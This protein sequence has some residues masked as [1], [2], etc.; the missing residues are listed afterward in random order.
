MSLVVKTV[1]P[2]LEMFISNATNKEYFQ[3]LL[4]TFL[5]EVLSMDKAFIDD[6]DVCDSRLLYVVCVYIARKAGLE[7]PSLDVGSIA[8]DDASSFPIGKTDQRLK[9]ITT[10][11]V[12]YRYALDDIKPTLD[13]D[14]YALLADFI[15]DCDF[16]LHPVPRKSYFDWIIED[17][18]FDEIDAYVSGYNHDDA[19]IKQFTRNDEAFSMKL[20]KRRAASNGEAYAAAARLKIHK[21]KW[22]HLDYDLDLGLHPLIDFDGKHGP[23]GVVWKHIAWHVFFDKMEKSTSSIP[24]LHSA[25]EKLIQ[26]VIETRGDVYQQALMTSGTSIDDRIKSIG[27]LR[28][29]LN[30]L[31]YIYNRFFFEWSS[32]KTYPDVL[33]HIFSLSEPKKHIHAFANLCQLA[34]NIFI[35]KIRENEARPH[36]SIPHSHA[37]DVDILTPSNTGVNMNFRPETIVI[38][39]NVYKRIEKL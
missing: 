22:S 31:R 37:G 32:R 14:V 17:E 16:E 28:G 20:W 23:A 15:D 34:V 35:L 4:A 11:C 3:T 27:C 38:N 33:A 18:L 30:E 5:K 2:A 8:F 24:E 29:H 26:N 21:L 12:K 39:G 36:N 25:F 7:E 6:Y 13:G 10:F 9:A 19:E 1:V